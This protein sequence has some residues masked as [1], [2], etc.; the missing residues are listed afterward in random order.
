[1]TVTTRAA[2]KKTS[3]TPLCLNLKEQNEGYK[4]ERESLETN[5]SDD[6]DSVFIDIE[7][8]IDEY[9]AEHESVERNISDDDR[10][11]DLAYHYYAYGT[12]TI[13]HDYNPHE[14]DSTTRIHFLKWIQRQL[15]NPYP[16]EDKEKE[17]F[18][19]N[20]SFLHHNV[21]QMYTAWEIATELGTNES[22]SSNGVP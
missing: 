11:F 8:E 21:R 15:N 19:E 17:A 16:I 4:A 18:W 20:T 22:P 6:V 10:E 13:E 5:I 2:A 3:S 9:N 7:R 1:M 14:F 12:S